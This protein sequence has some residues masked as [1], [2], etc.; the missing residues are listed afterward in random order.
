MRAA[1]GERPLPRKFRIVH[2]LFRNL[3]SASTGNVWAKRDFQRLAHDRR[4]RDGLEKSNIRVSGNIRIRTRV[5][6]PEPLSRSANWMETLDDQIHIPWHGLISLSGDCNSGSRASSYPGIRAIAA[7][8]SSCRRWRSSRRQGISTA[9]PFIGSGTRDCNQALVGAGR[10]PPA[11]CSRRSR[12]HLCISADPRSGRRERRP[13][14]Q[15]RL[16]RLLNVPTLSC[17]DHRKV[18]LFRNSIESRCPWD[19]RL[20]LRNRSYAPSTKGRSRNKAPL[21]QVFSLAT[22]S[23]L[24]SMREKN[25]RQNHI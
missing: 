9:F 6:L 7:T 3:N 24:V 13:Q 19:F 16:P 12:I 5:W 11:A 17:N 1:S 2:I 23:R 18:L 15:Q 25:M 10:P 8:R 21:T 20:P 4:F 22:R 14:D